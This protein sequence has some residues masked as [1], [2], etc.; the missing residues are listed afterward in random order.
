[1]T[2]KPALEELVAKTHAMLADMPV[3]L[4][5]Q[6]EGVQAQIRQSIAD[7]DVDLNDPAMARAVLVGALQMKAASEHEGPVPAEQLQL[8]LVAAVTDYIVR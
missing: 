1:M 4:R 8:V 2:Q 7:Y 6:F 3:G 5:S